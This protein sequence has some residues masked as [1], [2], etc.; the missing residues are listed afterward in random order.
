MIFFSRTLKSS[1]I[2]SIAK[3]YRVTL[4]RS[5][6]DLYR[7]YQ[8]DAILFPFELRSVVAQVG[9]DEIFTAGGGDILPSM[10]AE[11]V[12]FFDLGKQH[13]ALEKELLDAIRPLLKSATFIGGRAVLDFEERFRNLHHISHAVGVKSGTAA[14]RLA[15]LAMNLDPKAEVLVP[16]YTFIAT[17]ASVAQAGARPVFVDV[18]EET[19]SL[20]PQAVAAKISSR[21]Q[22]L[23]PVH[24]YGHPAPME[25]ILTLARKHGLRV[26]EDC[27]QSHL[28]TLNGRLTGTL[29]NAGAFSFYP[30]KNLGAG[31]D[32]GCVITGDEA[33]A[34]RVRLLANHGRS[35]RYHHRILGW[36]ERLDSIQAAILLVKLRHLEEWTTLRRRA[37]ARYHE[38][39]EGIAPWG[40]PLMLPVERESA[41][42]VY[43]LYVI[44]HSRRDDIATALAEQDIGTATHYPLSLPAQPPFDEES[45]A[46]RYPEATRWAATCLSLPF[47]PEISEA[48][49]TRVAQA[50][51]DL[52]S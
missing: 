4:A 14:L 44:R 52:P 37:A 41:V 33:L 9:R 47:F 31:G 49:Q 29:G 2:P 15:L 21:T 8:N 23:L 45:T 40:E 12:P 48:Q 26:L 11:P 20:D 6:S 51:K 10:P 43:H 22:V 35:D 3:R 38:L 36:N 46:E 39:L 42:H 5:G 1:H 28:A 25:P 13:Q 50:V 19:G 30:S 16:A 17:A 34:E 18:D 7:R 24:L 32:A 27:A